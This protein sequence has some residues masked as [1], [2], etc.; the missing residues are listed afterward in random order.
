M[1]SLVINLVN[2]C[3]CIFAITHSTLNNV[4]CNLCRVPNLD[5]LNKSR[6]TSAKLYK[7]FQK[8][9]KMTNSYLVS[10]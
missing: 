1:N 6:F 2:K 10:I 5:Y 3:V 9:K 7:D 8:G 4:S